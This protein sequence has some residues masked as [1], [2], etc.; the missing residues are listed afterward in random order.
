M[1]FSVRMPPSLPSR[2]TMTSPTSWS[3]TTAA[4]CWRVVVSSTLTASEVMRWR[5]LSVMRTSLPGDGGVKRPAVPGRV[6][7]ARTARHDSTV[8]VRPVPLGEATDPLRGTA[9]RQLIHR[10]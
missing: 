10:L 6:V 5:M 7:P 3:R 1:S 8:R 9:L 4:I 2:S